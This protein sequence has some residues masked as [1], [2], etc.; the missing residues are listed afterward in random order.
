MGFIDSVFYFFAPYADVRERSVGLFFKGLTE[1]SNQSATRARLGSLLQGNI[2]IINLWTEYQYK[3]YRYLSKSQRRKLYA[4]LQLIVDDFDHFYTNNAQP[5]ESVTAHIDRVTSGTAIDPRKAVL[6][7]AMMDY[8]S[9]ERRA[10]EYRE[11]SSFGRLLRDPSHEKLV[12]DCNQIVTLYIYLYSRYYDV[13]DLQIRLLPRHV[14]LHYG[15]IDIEAT[16]GRFTDYEKQKDSTLLPIEEIVSVNLLDATDSYLSTHEVSAENFL[17]A[18]RFAFILSHDRGIVTRNL[19]AAYNKLINSLMKRHNY[20]QALKFATASHDVTLLGMV[21]HNGTIYEMERHNYVAARRFA[22]YAPGAE[23]L[24]RKSWESEGVH[25]YQSHRYHDAIK[26]FKH[27]N[28]QVRV[29]QCYEALF[30][31]EQ[32]KLGSNLT[33]ESIKK[34][35]SVIKRMHVYAK[36]SGNKKLIEYAA[37]LNKALIKG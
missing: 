5:A 25:Y 24:T 1:H 33:T 3:G 31:D 35:T 10:Y 32:K 6:L 12:G 19:D 36:K 14:A 18:S 34:Y 22:K 13:R 29:G 20:H 27:S 11:S 7:Q 28:D 16:T 9:Q 17:Q 23:E 30:F 2:A 21:G 4:N 8:F 26:A 15:G 37:H